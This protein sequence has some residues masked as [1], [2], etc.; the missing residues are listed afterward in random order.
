MERKLRLIPS[1][2]SADQLH[3][4]DEIDRVREWGLLHIDIEDGNFVPNITFGEKMI[5]SAAAYASQQLDA[6]ILA[7]DPVQYLPMLAECGVKMAAAHIEALPY[8]LAFLNRA[9][10]LGMESGLALN[11][12]TP[13]EA[14]LPFSTR[15][16][17]VIVMTAE[18]DDEG[19]QFFSPVL[20][21]I[22]RLREILPEKTSIWAD[23]GINAGNMRTVLESGADT[24]IM[25]R[26][27]FGS[28]D[29]LAELNRLYALV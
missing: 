22:R 23:G 9:R 29:P 3:I 28:A 7:N 19:Q 6:H 17:Y 13:A 24:L 25:G 1:I 14:V 4:A 16:D 20:G 15:I 21:K 2:A 5:R 26:C 10:A 8:P 11:F 12:S 18:P 27:V